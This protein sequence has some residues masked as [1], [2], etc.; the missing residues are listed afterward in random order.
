MAKKGMRRPDPKS[1]HGTE[2]NKKQKFPKNTVEPV[3]EIQGKAKSGHR[4]IEE[5]LSIH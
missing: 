5:P 4:K 3:P 1:S 2:S